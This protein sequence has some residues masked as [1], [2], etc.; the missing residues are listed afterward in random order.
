MV[1]II[2]PRYGSLLP[3][4]ISYTHAEFREAQGA[5]IPVFAI[6]VPDD[7][8]LGAEERGNSIDS[9]PRL[10]ALQPTTLWRLMRLGTNLAAVLAALSSARDR[11]DIGIGFLSF[12]NTN[13]TSHLNWPRLALSL[14]I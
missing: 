11:G 5:G 10:E 1:L 4:G 2:G 12:R 3:Q 9:R 8:H 13:D 7:A 6:R 14:A